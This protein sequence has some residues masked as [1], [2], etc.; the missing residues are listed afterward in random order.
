MIHPA[1]ETPIRKYL[2]AFT[3][4]EFYTRRIIKRS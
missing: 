4:G 1:S 3:A 2:G